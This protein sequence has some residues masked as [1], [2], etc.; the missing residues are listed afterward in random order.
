MGGERAAEH[1]ERRSLSCFTEALGDAVKKR[2]KVALSCVE[3]RLVEPVEDDKALPLAQ[4]T[5]HLRIR[6][7]AVG[8]R[9]RSLQKLVPNLKPHQH[10]RADFERARRTLL[11]W[12]EK[13]IPEGVDPK[14]LIG[15]A[16]VLLFIAE[17]LDIGN[18][19]AQIQQL[20]QDAHSERPG[21]L[22]E[23]I[24]EGLLN[25]DMKK[26][27]DETPNEELRKEY[28]NA[29]VWTPEEQC[30]RFLAKK[31]SY[32]LKSRLPRGLPDRL[33]SE[34]EDSVEGWIGDHPFNDQP[35]FE[36]Y[37]YARLLSQGS[38][39]KGLAKAVREYLKSERAEYR[40]TPL[41]LWFVTHTGAEKGTGEQVFVDAADFGFVYE[42]AL[43]DAASAT[44]GGRRGL[45]R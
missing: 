3:P 44:V 22:L 33:R 9:Q 26:V 38:V 2:I 18:P 43:A 13:S 41:L 1:Q 5:R 39:D 10:H 14:S 19:Y 6:F 32:E 27:V 24:A 25:R 40:P 42:S 21:A 11:D 17:L 35:L 15:Y 12:L 29:N 45:D 37:V 8:F 20:E 28:R 36:D 4:L 30:I 34:Y 23:K 7:V 16:P 31:A